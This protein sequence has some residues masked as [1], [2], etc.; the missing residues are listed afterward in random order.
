MLRKKACAVTLSLAL[1]CQFLIAPMANAGS[2]DDAI[3]NITKDPSYSKVVDQLNVDSKVVED[4]VRD[5]VN[6]IDKDKLNDDSHIK[7]VVTGKF[8]TNEALKEAVVSLPA[9]EYADAK[10]AV[11]E[12]GNTLR[13]ELLK[14]P[15]V[16]G[17]AGGGAVGS[18]EFKIQTSGSRAIVDS[19]SKAYIYLNGLQIK[20]VKDAR[21]SLEMRFGDVKLAF[22]TE[23]LN[24]GSVM[25]EEKAEFKVRVKQLASSEMNN[26]MS[27]AKNG[28]VYKVA[29]YIYNI[30]SEAVDKSSNTEALS[31]FSGSITVS[32]PVPSEYRNSASTGTLKVYT[33]NEKTKNW[34]LV[35]GVFNSSANVMNFDTK[36][37]SQYALLEQVTATETIPQA[38]PAAPVLKE[39]KD[40]EGHWAAS[41][42]LYMASQGYVNGVEADKF[43]PQDL[44]TRAEFAT[45][46]VNVLG[47][48]GQGEV[49]FK[50]V[51]KG[52]WYYPSVALACKAGLAKGKGAD[53]FAPGAPITRQEMA[54]MLVNAMSYKGM[55]VQAD[56][57]VLAAFA[58][59]AQVADWAKPSA[60]AAYA[61]QIIKGKPGQ[62]GLCFGPTDNTTRAEAVVMLK[63]FLL[64]KK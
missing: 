46:L 41:D 20:E 17:V 6:S 3:S 24:I 39:F 15:A 49:V 50:D 1:S 14:D 11:K 23:A 12:L 53:T 47:L 42:I 30:T 21:K 25:G 38:K 51:N 58:D 28:G 52:A 62:K 5:V 59:Q 19:N 34:D 18:E 57:A 45:M 13:N 55:A 29:G 26:L 9:S 2:V 22:S 44:V 10:N 16:P 4:F 60:A 27:G 32:L 35:G 8:L 33:Y 54:A 43:H 40:I 64:T 56:T 48:Q 63:N 61:A 7:E 37:F 31:S 36:H